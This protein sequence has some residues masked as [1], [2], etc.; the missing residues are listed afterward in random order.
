MRFQFRTD[1]N[2]KP[3][4]DWDK[5]HLYLQHRKADT[6]WDIEIKPHERKVSDPMRKLYFAVVLPKFA[7]H[8]GYDPDEEILLHR[9]LKIIFFKIEPDKKGIYRKVPSVFGN[10]SDLVISEK[11][12]FFDW[13]LRK[14]SIE[15][16]YIE[17]ER[18]E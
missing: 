7:N 14:A 17:T 16:C 10:D 12:R 6:V 3:M 8:L 5:V 2:R 4:I 1:K 9:Q 15:G 11:K 18:S 13:V